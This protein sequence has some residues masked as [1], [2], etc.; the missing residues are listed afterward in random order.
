MKVQTRLGEFELTT[1]EENGVNIITHTSLSLL[2]NTLRSEG[3]I[4]DI[5]VP[6]KEQII[7]IANG[8]YLVEVRLQDTTTN[9]VFRGIGEVNP[10]NIDTEISLN[11]PIMM[12]FN[13]A[14]DKAFLAL[15]GCEKRGENAKFYSSIEMPSTDSNGVK[16]K[17][18]EKKSTPPAIPPLEEMKL[19]D[20]P[21]VKEVTD[22]PQTAVEELKQIINEP[23]DVPVNE[24]VFEEDE[25]I[26]APVKTSSAKKEEMGPLEEIPKNEPISEPVETTEEPVEEPVET[27][28]E[29][30]TP[31]VDPK[32]AAGDMVIPSGRLAGKKLCEADEDFVKWF[33]DA[34]MYGS[35]PPNYNK[36]F[37]DAF[38]L[39][40][41]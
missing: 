13:R 19:P 11:N 27:P 15:L 35:C 38:N 7:D 6:L 25:P 14:E 20:I 37:L 36:D 18:V 12:A 4:V 41:S 5:F 39:F 28:V 26:L 31:T 32:K 23:V 30:S 34:T 9:A 24:E 3:K 17:K 21:P 22:I 2:L 16:E 33:K 10:R 8:V 1:Y 29:E 40:V